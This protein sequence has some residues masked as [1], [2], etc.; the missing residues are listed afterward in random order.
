MGRTVS[1]LIATN[2]LVSPI[3]SLIA[4]DISFSSISPLCRLA[5]MAPNTSPI[6]HIEK[7]TRWAP[8]WIIARVLKNQTGAK[9]PVP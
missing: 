6:F 7:A 9:L 1:L 8:D 5:S 2:F 4:S 3:K